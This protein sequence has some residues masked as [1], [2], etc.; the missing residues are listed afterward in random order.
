[1]KTKEELKQRI[2]EY[3][4]ALVK[5]NGKPAGNMAALLIH[6]DVDEAVDSLYAEIDRL[7]KENEE[8]KSNKI[9]VVDMD[10]KD[11]KSIAQGPGRII[12]CVTIDRSLVEREVRTCI[13]MACVREHGWA[14]YNNK[15]L[16]AA[17]LA[18]VDA[19][20][21]EGER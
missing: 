19:I 20:C 5:M 3:G 2:N 9:Y 1:M 14:K 10:S 18:A 21:G 17:I 16:E 15:E 12:P 8:L 11:I 7:T 4:Q 6:C 13:G